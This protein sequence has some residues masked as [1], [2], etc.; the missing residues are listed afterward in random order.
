M[1]NK[2][3]CVKSG[4]ELGG[5]GGES[6][7]FLQSQQVAQPSEVFLILLFDA[8]QHLIRVEEV[9]CASTDSTLIYQGEQIIND[10]VK[11]ALNAKAASVTVMHYCP[12]L[13]FCLTPLDI[14]IGQGL[15]CALEAQ[16]IKLLDYLFVGKSGSISLVEKVVL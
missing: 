12:N 1:T 15:Q 10:A 7:E 6:A 4:R 8:E 3:N 14:A 11:Q 2:L 13:E 9:L 5:L 16:Q